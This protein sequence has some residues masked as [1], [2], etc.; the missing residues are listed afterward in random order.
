[1]AACLQPA[2]QRGVDLVL[3]SRAGA[4]EL[5]AASQPATAL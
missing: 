2:H 5:L 4:D 1:M 3:G